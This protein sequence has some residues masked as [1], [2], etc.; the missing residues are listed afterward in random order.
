MLK[1]LAVLVKGELF[2]L[3]EI[4]RCDASAVSAVIFFRVQDCVHKIREGLDVEAA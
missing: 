2:N 4:L 3:S 1:V